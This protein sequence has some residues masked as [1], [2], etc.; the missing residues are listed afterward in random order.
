MFSA[1]E[2]ADTQVQ[3]TALQNKLTALQTNY[4]NF[5]ANSQQQAT[6]VLTIVESASLPIKPIG[7][8]RSLII[9]LSVTLGMVLAAGAAYALEY[10][11]DSIDSEDDI[12]QAVGVPPLIS[13]EKSGADHAYPT[14]TMKS[15]RSPISESFRDLRTRVLFLSLNKPSGSLLITS[16][17]PY[18]GKSFTA[19]NLAVVMAQAGYRTILVDGDLRR[20]RQHKIFELSNKLG[21]S[22]LIMEVNTPAS[23]REDAAGNSLGDLL[24]TVI[25]ETQQGGLMVLTSGTIPPNPSELIGSN[26]MIAVVEALRER[27]DYVIMDSSPCLAVTDALLLSSLSDSVI[28]VSSANQTRG[29]NLKKA[30]AR[31]EEVDANV[32]GVVLNRATKA[33]RGRFSYYQPYDSV[34]DEAVEEV[35][36]EGDKDSS[37]FRKRMLRLTTSNGKDPSS[38]SEKSDSPNKDNLDVNYGHDQE[39]QNR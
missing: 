4:T 38:L 24:D 25:Q 6:N 10:I 29:K 13:L 35:V 28:L 30:V 15:P 9:L 12:R 39:I 26:G 33:K 5:L 16:A 27:F 34:E 19:A 3:I 22:N 17:G 11:D 32:V 8:N 36:D 23:H 18:E 14:L 2:I 1:R 7:P 37:G 21:L 31:L 20:P